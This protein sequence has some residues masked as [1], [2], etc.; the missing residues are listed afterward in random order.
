MNY[1]SSEAYLWWI[2]LKEFAKH[3]EK[4][5][6]EIVYPKLINDKTDIK[7]NCASKI[8]YLLGNE[9]FLTLNFD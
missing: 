8:R 9:N 4:G 5:L 3:A 1:A 6:R 2:T 7:K